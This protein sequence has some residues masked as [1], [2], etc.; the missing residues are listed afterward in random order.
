MAS[1]DS[2]LGV[3]VRRLL[4]HLAPM[5]R[6]SL[7]TLTGTSPSDSSA[8]LRLASVSWTLCLAGYWPVDASLVRPPG[9][10]VPLTLSDAR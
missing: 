7:G 8:R 3:G 9:G 4:S 10:A 5:F 2:A 1:S 6:R